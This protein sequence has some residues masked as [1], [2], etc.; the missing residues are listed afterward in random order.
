MNHNECPSL[1]LFLSGIFV[2][3]GK[4]NNADLGYPFS[5]SLG[6]SPAI[7]FLRWS[8]EIGK[9]PKG[10]LYPTVETLLQAY[11]S[12]HKKNAAS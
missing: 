7:Y 11:F 12:K 4:V 5:I 8:P 10:V 6:L 2:T 1:G 9:G 3:S